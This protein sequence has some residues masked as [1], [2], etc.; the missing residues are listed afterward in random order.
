MSE[1]T[2]LTKTV[3]VL[4][5]AKRVYCTVKGSLL[6]YCSALYSH[7]VAVN[8]LAERVKASPQPYN[9]VFAAAQ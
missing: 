3:S 5:V 4:L 7:C 9:D 6:I 1:R 2:I 8:D